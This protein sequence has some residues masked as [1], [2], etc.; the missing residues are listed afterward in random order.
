VVKKTISFTNIGWDLEEGKAAQGE[1]KTGRREESQA[2]ATGGTV[3]ASHSSLVHLPADSKSELI[4][5]NPES[6]E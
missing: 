1:A 4:K 2:R 6:I 5:I 3:H